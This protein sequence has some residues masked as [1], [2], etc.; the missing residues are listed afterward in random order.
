[1]RSAGRQLGDIGEDV[2]AIGIFDGQGDRCVGEVSAT[3]LAVAATFKVGNGFTV[4]GTGDDFSSIVLKLATGTTFA[5]KGGVLTVGG[6][7][8]PI[9]TTGAGAL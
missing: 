3:Q 1:M 6:V 9:V 5:T 7:L 8:S 2:G 4:N